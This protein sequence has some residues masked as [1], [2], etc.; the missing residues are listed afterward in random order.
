[1]FR[2]F[3]KLSIQTALTIATTLLIIIA[4]NASACAQTPASPAST[5]NTGDTA[6]MLV[7]AAFV[8]LMTPGLAFFYGGM[9]RSKNVLNML[10]QS[11]V[12]LGIV[13]LVWLLWG[14]SLAFAPGNPFIGSLRWFGLNHVGE[15]PS[16]YY[17]PTIPHQVYMIYQLMFAIITPALISGAIAE[18]MKFSTY[19]V[20]ITLW[21]TFIYCPLAHW[22]WGHNGWLNNLGALDFAG[23]T[24]VHISSGVSALVLAI[25]L[26]R[27]HTDALHSGEEMR[28]H[29]LTMTLVGTALLWF[30]WFGFNAGSAL[31]SGGLAASAFVAT[32]IAAAI[33]GLTWIL[34]EWSIYKKPTALGFATGAVA[35][36]VAITPASGYVGPVP[37]LLIGAGVAFISFYAIKLKHKF[38]YDDALDVFGVHGMGGVWGALATGLFASVLVNSSGSN[39][40]FYGGGLTLLLKQ[41]IA[42]VSAVAYAAIGTW[43]L[44]KI[45]GATMG[46]RVRVEEE[47]VGLDLTQHGESAYV[48]A[49]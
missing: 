9:V 30:G 45:L 1:M 21:S 15:N 12:A 34:I 31:A 14:Y 20:F 44:T 28:P 5:I 47:N 39:G 35:G 10:M 26:G 43:I 32:H 11:F 42:V 19:V 29:N 22:V 33:A 23:G 49:E 24:V 40:L 17:A 36:L 46:L 38:H 25:A 3:T 37:A 18:R 48:M 2:K 7:A 16:S 41:T 6:W 27:R 4:G 13:T 8:M